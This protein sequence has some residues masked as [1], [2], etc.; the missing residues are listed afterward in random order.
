MVR[1]LDADGVEVLE[2]KLAQRGLKH[3]QERRCER[4]EACPEDAGVVAQKEHR[5]KGE[6]EASHDHYD[7][8]SESEGL[9]QHP[10]DD[11]RSDSR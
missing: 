5:L 7:K 10:P 1:A 4:S 9:G 3:V 6:R 2:G 11:L 8:N